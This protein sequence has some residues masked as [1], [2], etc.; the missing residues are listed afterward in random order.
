MVSQG[1]RW[2]RCGGEVFCCVAGVRVMFSRRG[3]A[4][5]FLF[6]LIIIFRNIIRDNVRGLTSCARS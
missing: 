3:S 6:F 1:V 5:F 4:V 2:R